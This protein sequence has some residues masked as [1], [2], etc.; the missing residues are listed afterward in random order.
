MRTLGQSVHYDPDGVMP[1][2]SSWQM[3]HKVHRDAIPFPHWYLQGLHNPTGSLMLY[4]CLLTGQTCRHELCYLLLHT[5]PPE[6]FLEILVHLSHARMQTETTFV[7]FLQD[8][9]LH[10]DIV[11][12]THHALKSKYAITTQGKIPLPLLTP[13]AL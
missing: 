5:L 10:L 2:K 6:I 3:G 4:L 8:Q 9:L 12:N 13:V 7:S 11:G 1:S